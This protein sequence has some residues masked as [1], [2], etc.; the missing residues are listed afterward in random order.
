MRVAQSGESFFMRSVA[1]QTSCREKLFLGKK[2]LPK[3]P[4]QGYELPQ[5]DT[6]CADHLGHGTSSLPLL[7]QTMRQRYAVG[8]LDGAVAL[9]RIAAPYLHPRV[10]AAAPY[11]EL[12]AIPDADLDAVRSQD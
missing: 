7:L 1:D 5:A 11:L 6:P 12:A 3:R 4:S 2:A 10:P 8:D 9:A